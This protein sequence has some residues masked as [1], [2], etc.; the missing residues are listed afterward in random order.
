MSETLDHL[1]A[2][3]NRVMGWLRAA[4]RPLLSWAR[5]LTVPDGK[6]SGA[7]STIPR[8]NKIVFKIERILHPRLRFR[9][10]DWSSKI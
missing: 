6:N 5:T 8:P 10:S 4:S 3:T 2:T 7:V 9:A 1:L